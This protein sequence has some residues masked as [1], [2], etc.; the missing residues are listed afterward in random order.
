[1]LLGLASTFCHQ[2]KLL[3]LLQL[4]SYSGD[5][6]RKT[7]IKSAAQSTRLFPVRWKREKRRGN[8]CT[9]AWNLFPYNAM[10]TRHKCFIQEFCLSQKHPS[11]R[12]LALTIHFSRPTFIPS[13]RSWSIIDCIYFWHNSQTAKWIQTSNSRFIHQLH[14][15]VINCISTW[16]H[17]CLQCFAPNKQTHFHEIPIRNRFNGQDRSP[18]RCQVWDKAKINEGSSASSASL[19]SSVSKYVYTK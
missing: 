15:Q 1:M 7:L 13:E 16:Y 2:L 4:N 12:F 17:Q 6:S 9:A 5:A 11:N 19:A 8:I 10:L 14:V 3:L 18:T